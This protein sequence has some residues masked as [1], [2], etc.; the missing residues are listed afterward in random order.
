MAVACVVLFHANVPPFTGGFVGVDV[1]FV[2]SGFLITRLLADELSRT[3]RVSF[4]N[5]YVRRARRILPALFFTIALSGVFA[6]LLLS[7]DALERFGGSALYAVLSLSN[8]FFWQ[9]SGYFDFFSITKPL[10][11]TWSL[12]V[13][14]QFYAFWPL[15]LV[16]LSALGTRWVLPAI[17]G[18]GVVSLWL[19]GWFLSGYAEPAIIAAFPAAAD[20]LHEAPAT[21]FFLTPFRVFEFA[22]GA[23]MVWAA[24]FRLPRLAL[25]PILVVGLGMIGYAVVAY[26]A[27][28]PFPYLAA[29]VPC[30]GAALVIYA[31]TAR[32]TGLLL[33]NPV[34][35]GAGL[36]SYSIYLLHWPVLVF[37]THYKG[38]PPTSVET[39]LLI[40]A[41]LAGAV[42]MYR[43]VELPF[44]RGA[45]A[46][47]RPRTVLAATAAAAAVLVLPAWLAWT[48]GGWEWRIPEQRRAMSADDWRRLE[49]SEYCQNWHP[50]LPREPVSCQNYRH[51]TRDIFIWGDSHALHLVPGFSEAYPD[52]NVYVLYQSA[53]TPQSGIAGYVRE[54]ADKAEERACIAHNKATLDFL[55]GLP[56]TDIVISNAKRSSPAEIAGPTNYLLDQLRAMG[57]RAFVLGDFIR[58][59]VDLA[60]CNNVPNY[61]LSNKANR[62]RCK[63]NLAGIA[64]ELRYNDVLCPLLHGFVEVSEI[65]C[66]DRAEC[67]FFD[68]KTP[69]FRDHHHL[70][71]PGSTLFVGALKDRLPIAAIPASPTAAR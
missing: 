10:L 41:T 1:F 19:N 36:A 67:R 49:R 17:V 44:R 23:A 15:L 37:F 25:E 53:C 8:V 47:A 22:I 4:P 48:E 70:N 24:G 65:Q 16:A 31:G 11:H 27:A 69:L 2:I 64:A 66:P 43:F 59:G 40:A 51:A 68:G 50:S 60:G 32:W 54:Y 71:I 61:L 29:L 20:W 55:A 52:R 33:R 21:V 34:A 12:G 13:E 28:T 6:F 42:A 45:P 30:F 3:G 39:A 7:P 62:R 9:E 26:S 56:P 57:H 38:R 46:S 14:E 35:V 5:F 18:L 58:P 63:P